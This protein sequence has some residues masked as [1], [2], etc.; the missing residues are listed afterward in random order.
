MATRRV[1]SDRGKPSNRAVD[2]LSAILVGD[3]AVGDIAAEL[4]RQGID[5][6][7]AVL[8]M[9]RKM[10]RQRTA[11]QAAAVRPINLA[12]MRK[13]PPPRRVSNVKQRVPEVPF[14][15]NGTLHD[16][17][18]IVRYNSRELHFIPTADGEQL[19]VVEDREL[20][21]T[22]RQYLFLSNAAKLP[23]KYLD[24]PGVPKPG[25]AKPQTMPSPIPP[26]Q[27]GGPT[28]GP[29]GG[30]KFPRPTLTRFYEDENLGGD[31]IDLEPN[32]GYF[33]LTHVGKGAFGLGDWNDEISSV[34]MQYTQVCV[35]HEDIHWAGSTLNLFGT[36][37]TGTFSTAFPSF[38]LGPLGWNDRA[39]SLETW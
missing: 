9:V 14:L 25:S 17:K 16:P 34:E 13:K 22:W 33:D 8:E 19:L 27:P 20:I 28:L 6:V 7:P 2:L 1:K 11:A 31:F 12:G 21:T 39:S 3:A 24:L 10:A 23:E 26:G 32:R 30:G 38:N 15:L 29:V 37:Y 18:D 36:T 35:L 4:R 5:S